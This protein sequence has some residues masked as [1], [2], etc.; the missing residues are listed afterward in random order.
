MP[1]NSEVLLNLK[2]IESLA[3]DNFTSRHDDI[4]LLFNVVAHLCS[5]YTKTIMEK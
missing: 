4:M 1:V 2:N 3:H 5:H